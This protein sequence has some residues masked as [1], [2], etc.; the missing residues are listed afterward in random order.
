MKSSKILISKK[1]LTKSTTKPNGKAICMNTAKS[2]IKQK[3]LKTHKNSCKSSINNILA[4]QKLNM[5][6]S[7]RNPIITLKDNLFRPS[8]VTIAQ[9]NTLKN[10]AGES[11]PDVM[12][13][14]MIK[15]CETWRKCFPSRY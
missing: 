3:T 10:V 8:E 12:M 14:K 9:L 2:N 7:V 6:L 11:G 4:R 5:S 1:Y 15:T 13:Q